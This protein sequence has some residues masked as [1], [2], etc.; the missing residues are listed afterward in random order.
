MASSSSFFDHA[1]R[2]CRNRVRGPGRAPWTDGV[3]RLLGACCTIPTTARMRSRRR[4]WSWSRRL[5]A[6]GCVIRWGLGSIRL[7]FAP[8]RV[9]ARRLCDVSVSS[10]GHCQLRNGG[11]HRG[12][13]RSRTSD[14]PRR[15]RPAARSSSGALGPLR[16]PGAIPRTGCPPS[17]LAD[18]NGKKP[19]GARPRAAPRATRAARSCSECGGCIVHA[20]IWY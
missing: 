9:L 10:G 13:R 15:D 3:A 8:P 11:F 19:P 17:G 20:R 2:D 6:S 7:R 12:P 14:S 5:A 16:P 1:R 18:R 4:F